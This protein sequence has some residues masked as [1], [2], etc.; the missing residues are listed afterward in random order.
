MNICAERG[1]FAFLEIASAMAKAPPFLPIIA[2]IPPIVT[3]CAMI[4]A[5]QLSLKTPI[6]IVTTFSKLP[7]KSAKENPP[8]VDSNKAPD[9]IPHTKE[10]YTF[11]V[12]KAR[13]IDNTGGIS[14]SMPKAMAFSSGDNP[15]DNVGLKI[16]NR[17]R[18]L[19][20]IMATPYI[21]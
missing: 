4:V 15:Q 20:N 18:L 8:A 16:V 5:L 1:V 11:F 21:Y 3:S 17:I 14:V 7:Y 9:Q 19:Y 13:T 10:K 12:T 2:I 6:I